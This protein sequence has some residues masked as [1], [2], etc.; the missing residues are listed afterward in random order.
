MLPLQMVEAGVAANIAL[1]RWRLWRDEGGLEHGK[2]ALGIADCRP[3]PKTS[4]IKSR[5]PVG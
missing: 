2:K 1:S 4:R 5:L 3:P